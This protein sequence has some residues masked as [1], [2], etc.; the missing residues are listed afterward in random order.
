MKK[1]IANTSK[2]R[3]NRFDPFSFTVMLPNSDVSYV[4]ELHLIKANLLDKI[5]EKKAEENSISKIL[6]N[7]DDWTNELG[8]ELRNRFGHSKTL[9][10]KNDSKN[11]LEKLKESSAT[12]IERF[13]NVFI[14]IYRG[15]QKDSEDDKFFEQFLKDVNAYIDE[16]TSQNADKI[17]ITQ[18]KWLLSNIEEV[19]DRE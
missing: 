18:F 9:L 7:E 19:K 6:E 4:E 15:K 17:I 11:I 5:S 3:I 12:D 14:E 10:Y 13:R 2:E 16:L 1:N 8:K